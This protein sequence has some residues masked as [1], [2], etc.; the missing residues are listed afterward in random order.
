[1]PWYKQFIFWLGDFVEDGTT[2]KPSVKRYGVAL[3][4]TVLAGVMF[5]LGAVIGWAV[6]Q[7]D[8]ADRV[9]IVESATQALIDVC[10]WFVLLVTGNYTIGKMVEKGL[11][12]KEKSPE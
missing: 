3:G 2:G 7:T 9:K 12:N 5:G 6:V 10:M 11:G 4:A 1:M 8:G